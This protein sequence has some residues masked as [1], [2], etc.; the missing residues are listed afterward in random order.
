[1][2]NERKA[3]AVAN[4]NIALVKYWGKRDPALILP[5]NGSM[6]MTCEGLQ[7][8]TTVAFAGEG[9]DEIIIN[10]DE[11]RKDEKDIRGHLDRIRKLAGIQGKAR[12]VSETNFP[13]AAGL[14]SSASGLAALTL[15]AAAAAGLQLSPK[16]LSILARQ[17]SGS[18]CRSILGGFV[19]WKRGSQPDG[20]DS[21]AL[22][23]APPQH[24]PDF[25]MVACIVSDK[26]KPVGSRAGMAQT[27]ATCPYYPQWVETATKDLE[28]VRQ[29]ILTKDFLA[30]AAA[31]ELNALKMHA[32]MMTT[33]P[34]IIYWTPATLEVMHAVRAW[35]EEG[36]PAYFTMDAGPQVKILTLEPQL[37]EV[38]RRLS[39]LEGVARTIVCTPGQGA[40]L[41]EKHL[42]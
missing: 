17:G 23:V 25:R 13:V 1:M 38:E 4:A 10:D 42:F 16:D 7:T 2:A 30:V 19:E 22:Q 26:A 36:I 21:Y 12:I 41:Q 40:A 37:A 29:G 8:I 3:T 28:T 31:A 20:T 11:L 14:A 34:P 18:A 24:W 35:R 6:S 5:Y 15:A 33:T 32:T 27:V 39:Q 9:Q